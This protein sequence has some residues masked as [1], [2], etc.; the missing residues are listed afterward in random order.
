M[1]INILKTSL[2]CNQLHR[3]RVFFHNVK[4]RNPVYFK[5]GIEKNLVETYFLVL[6]YL[7]VVLK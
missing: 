3:I 5:L 1:C 6:T 2:G 4:K 7:R